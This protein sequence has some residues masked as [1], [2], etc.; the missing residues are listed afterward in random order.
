M[1]E[2]IIILTNKGIIMTREE[3]IISEAVNLKWVE[4]L[5]DRLF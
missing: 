2:D 1:S 4:K 5:V 3:A